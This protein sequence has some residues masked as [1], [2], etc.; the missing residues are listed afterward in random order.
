MSGNMV[1][2]TALFYVS[3]IGGNLFT[4]MDTRFDTRRKRMDEQ[5]VND[6]LNISSETNQSVVSEERT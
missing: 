5:C 2:F 6:Y 1:Y 3:L 4:F